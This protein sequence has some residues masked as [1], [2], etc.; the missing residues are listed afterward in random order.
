[1]IHLAWGPASQDEDT[2]PP[3]PAPHLPVIK[4]SPHRGGVSPA[5]ASRGSSEALPASR[6]ALCRDA[7]GPRAREPW[8]PCPR[9][10]DCPELR[11]RGFPPNTPLRASGSPPRPAHPASSDTPS[12]H[13]ALPQQ[14]PSSPTSYLLRVFVRIR[15]EAPRVN[16]ILGE[17]R[18]YF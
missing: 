6:C 2:A 12:P 9:L 15:Y 5:Q 8:G 11:G 7:R 16:N 3:T 4:A 1:M 18:I 10:S 14:L 13:V 17:M